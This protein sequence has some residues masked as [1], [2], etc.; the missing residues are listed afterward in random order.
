[1]RKWYERPNWK[2]SL[3]FLKDDKEIVRGDINPVDY[4][5]M[6]GFSGIPIP[7][8]ILFYDGSGKVRS[9]IDSDG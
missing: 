8:R 6:D 4:K 1:M 7:R 3:F 2:A 5:K 9:S